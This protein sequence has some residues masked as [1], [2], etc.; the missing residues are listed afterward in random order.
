MTMEIVPFSGWSRNARIVCNDVEML[1]TLDV[2]PR[3][4]SYGFIGGPNELHVSEKT[5]GQTGGDEFHSYGG[6]RLWI[7]PE[8]DPKTFTPDNDAVEYTMDGDWHVFTGKPD[9]FHVV[10][11][12]RIKPE[13]ANSRFVLEHRVYNR[14]GY[15]L[16]FAPW[17]PTQFAPGG[18][19][20]FPQAAYIAHAD[21][22]LPA[23]PL[24]LWHY[25]NMSDDRWTWGEKVIRLQWKDRPA[26]KV[27]ATVD[28]GY[29][30]YANHG[31][32]HL[33]RFLY[34]P[35]ATYADF[36]CNFETFS[37]HDMLEVETLSPLQTVQPGDYAPHFETWYL[38]GNE[39]PPEEDGACAEWLAGLA[40]TR[41][42]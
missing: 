25:T 32:V 20:I 30:A 24:V 17:T 14:S 19:C 39:S 8:E 40:A 2:G 26:T 36:G 28:Q 16:T 7:A 38:I 33:R 22:V 23:R 29:C 9:T 3:I 11:E 12:I 1:V 42:I 34:D 27:G 41:P 37:R 6:H 13:P 5:A 15:A 31:N 35:E 21:K 10:R 4:I 18:V